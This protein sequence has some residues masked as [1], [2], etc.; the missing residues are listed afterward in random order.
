MSI[1]TPSIASIDALAAR[2]DLPADVVPALVALYGAHLEGHDGIAPSIIAHVL[3]ELPDD[4]RWAEALG[5]GELAARGVVVF[6]RSRVRIAR[7]VQR[8]L[9]ELPPETGTIIGAPDAVTLLG[10]CVI[11]DGSDNAFDIAARHAARAGGAI[12]VGHDDRAA[13]LV[14]FEARAIGAAAMLPAHKYDGDLAAPV[15][16][17]AI[18]DDDADRLGLPRFA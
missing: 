17:I 2:F 4:H 11:V 13:S 1:A 14:S 16:Y 8:V 6:E 18:D 12:L 10:A 3:G 7:A 15:I 9:D 5:R